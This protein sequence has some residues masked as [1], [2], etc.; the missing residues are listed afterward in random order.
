MGTPPQLIFCL[1]D[2]TCCLYL[3]CVWHQLVGMSPL[4]FISIGHWL[5]FSP[6]PWTQPWSLG[7]ISDEALVGVFSHGLSLGH[8]ASCMM[9]HWLEF[10]PLLW[11]QPWTLGFISDGALVGVLSCGL[12]L[13][14]WASFLVGDWL[15]LSLSGARGTVT[16]SKWFCVA[17]VYSR[18]DTRPAVN[19]C[20]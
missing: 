20:Q 2:H 8:F 13:G 11:T 6:L 14:H 16:P 18:L 19:N 15:G 1:C 3:G 10:S 7:F 4:G 5:A 9:G 12:S 17:I